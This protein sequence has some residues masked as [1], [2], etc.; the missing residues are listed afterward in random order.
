V[1]T[2]PIEIFRPG[3]HQSAGGSILTFSSADMAGM[4]SA[5][6]PSLHEAPAVVGHPAHDRP[7]YGWVKRLG[8]QDGALVAWFDQL[9]PE[10]AELV[11]K[12][13]FKKISAAFYRPDAG[14]NPTPGRWYLRHVG[15]LGAQPPAVKGLRPV[16]F[17]EAGG[18][19]GVVVFAGPPVD[20]EDPQ[21]LAMAARALQASQARAGIKVTV[22]DA[23][24][25]VRGGNSV[26]HAEP[27]AGTAGLVAAAHAYQAQMAEAGTRVTIAAAVRAVRG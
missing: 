27:G 8:V 6:D 15:F 25:Q 20:V 23:V 4:V 17:G 12:G 14:S 24:H 3:R 22:A 11:R 2:A 18:E 5:Y 9:D 10:F 21:A 19:L 1:A 7:A 16:Q 26:Q 13:R